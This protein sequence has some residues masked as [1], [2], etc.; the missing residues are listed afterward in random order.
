[1]AV[2]KCD[3]VHLCRVC[4]LSREFALETRDSRNSSKEMSV[5]SRANVQLVALH[6]GKRGRASGVEAKAFCMMTLGS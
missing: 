4:G 5:P 3:R 2:S 1:M 6:A